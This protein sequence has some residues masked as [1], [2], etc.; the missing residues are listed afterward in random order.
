M[1]KEDYL[2]I[3]TDLEAQISIRF[4]SLQNGMKEAFALHHPHE[5]VSDAFAKFLLASILLGSFNKNQEASLMKLRY[6][7]RGFG[8]N[9]EVSPRGPYRAAIVGEYKTG[10]KLEGGKFDVVRIEKEQAPYHSVT[11]VLSDD[12]NDIFKEYLAAS[13]QTQ[14]HLFLHADPDLFKK[15]FGMWIQKLPNTAEETWLTMTERFQ[16]RACFGSS[17]KN[18]S[19]PDKIIQN[20]FPDK[21]RILSVTKPKPF[22]SCSKERIIEALK[23]LPEADLAEIF[24]EGNGVKTRCDYCCTTWEVLDEEIKKLMKPKETLH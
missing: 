10:I 12:V 8:Y 13:E 23:L 16:E 11:P 20:L 2:L 7:H 6:A 15:N 4:L 21:I 9:C 22:C 3:A 1:K 5:K 24:I 19:D 18:T 14:S 17:F